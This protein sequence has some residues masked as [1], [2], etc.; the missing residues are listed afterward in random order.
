MAYSVS[1]DFKDKIK[2]Q[3]S[4]KSCL[5]LFDDCF[6]AAK[7]F[8]GEVVFSQYFNTSEDLTYGDCP[9]DT[10]SFSVVSG[11]LLSGYSFGKCRTYAGVQTASESYTFGD[12][13]AHIEVGGYTWTA[14][15][16]GL[17]C[18]DTLIDSGEYVSLVSDGV[19]VLASGLT[20]AYRANIDGSD[21]SA[22]A[23][24]RF[25]AE[26]LKSGIS[27]VFDDLTAHV[28]DGKNLLTYEYVP[29]GVYNVAKPRSTVGD[30][31]EVQDAYDDMQKFDI[32]ASEFVSGLSF[33]M[34][35]GGI[36]TALCEYVGVPYDTDTFSGSDTSYSSS[37][38]SESSY[39]CRD[40]LSWIAEASHT[41][42]HMNRVGQ[43]SLVWLSGD[44]ESIG[45][46]DISMDGYS[47]AEYHTAPVTGVLLK[48]TQGTTLSFGSMDTPYPIYA[49]PFV[50]TIPDLTPY[51]SIPAYVPMELEIFDADP[52]VSVGDTMNVQPLAEEVSAITDTFGVIYARPVAIQDEDS[53]R[54]AVDEDNVVYAEMTALAVQNPIYAVPLMNREF[55]FNG[56][57]RA[58]YSATGNETR[59]IGDEDISYNASVA[60][61]SQT[62]VFNRLTN[63]GEAQGIYLENGKIY[64][65]AEYVQ[66]GVLRGIEISNGNGSFHVSA[67]GYV[68]AT[69]G[70]IGGFNITADSLW[71]VSN[72]YSVPDHTLYGYYATINRHSDQSTDPTEPFI[73]ILYG[74]QYDLSNA[75]SLFELAYNG[76]GKFGNG[77]INL[78]PNGV[79]EVVDTGGVLVSK[80]EIVADYVNNN[81]RNV[82]ESRLRSNAIFQRASMFNKSTGVATS[83]RSTKVDAY[84]I[85]NWH[86]TNE[87]TAPRRFKLDE[88]GL[89]FYNASGT[90]TKSYPAT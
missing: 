23:P 51:T 20:S 58:K 46:S 38:F 89:Y 50:A 42:A 86:G 6:F 31:V 29:M 87:D 25:M 84:E 22:F 78:N 1:Q 80:I 11:G 49:N 61:I 3:T 12:I 19:H 47:M 17:Y 15:E 57:F 30:V 69:S 37:P 5:I 52:S 36:Y 75:D 18:G 59:D 14:S 48:S 63:G 7:D 21:G 39:R 27:A 44:A 64:V 33:P 40:I 9:S 26:K 54:V 4:A 16:T 68:T 65:N 74:A 83:F 2:D 67:N 79:L 71:S 62:D 43:M 72:Y 34:T 66:A 70:T 88:T 76:V 35:L 82:N 41:V 53:G 60:P 10:L 55:I 90:L 13:H 24:I 85:T 73:K 77:T 45:A 56:S 28:W 81:Y 8:T 32:D